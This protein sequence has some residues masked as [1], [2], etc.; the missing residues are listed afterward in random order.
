MAI[1]LC[2]SCM[3]RGFRR[4]RMGEA[5][6][7]PVCWGEGSVDAIACTDPEGQ[8]IADQRLEA[9]EV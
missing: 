9:E 2:P 7:C 3:G 8:W 4:D 6:D 1:I 5:E